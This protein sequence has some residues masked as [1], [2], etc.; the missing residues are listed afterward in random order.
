MYLPE[1]AII[2]NYRKR[3]VDFSSNGG[4]FSNLSNDSLPFVSII[5]PVYN[6][7][8]LIVPKMENLLLLK[9]PRDRVQ[10]IVVDG[11]S[12]DNT[13]QLA[14]K[15]EKGSEVIVF[16]PDKREGVTDAVKKGV[17]RSKG[18][19][20]IMT[21]AEALFDQNAISLVVKDL[22][23]SKIGAVSGCEVLSNPEGNTFTR[24]EK[25]YGSFYEK[26]RLAE[27]YLYSTSH[28][29]G[30]LVGV[31]RSLY[32]F[33][34]HPYKGLLDH[35]IAYNVIRQGYR[36]ICDEKIIFYDIAT[37][38][39]GDRNLQK[40][41]RA[42]LVEEDLFQNIDMALN[43]KFGL[44]GTVIMPANLLTH[45]AFPILFI[46]LLVLAP[47]VVIQLLIHYLVGTVILLV[48]GTITALCIKR[49]RIFLFTFFHSQI[50]LFI[51][52]LHLIFGKHKLIKQV[53]GTRRIGAQRVAKNPI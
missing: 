21:D 46:G 24:M 2:L 33:N 3:K 18:D 11:K 9:Y 48:A 28:F 52:M 5:L 42:I 17:L 51:G 14:R 12:N 39:L 26:M 38:N 20:I 47:F 30:E 13:L 1:I 25:T 31:R 10:I 15:Y 49:I 23:D 45:F 43:P 29:K 41:Q 16:Q 8:T 7:E 35:G 32:P 50:V 37:D 19:I 4:K 27:S 40:M 36:A 53:K 34:L 44:F 6:E 22:E